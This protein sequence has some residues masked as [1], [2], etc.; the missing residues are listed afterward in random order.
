MRKAKIYAQHQVQDYTLR[1]TEYEGMG[2]LSFTVET[3]ERCITSEKIEEVGNRNGT[4]QHTNH[5]SRYLANHLKTSSHYRVLQAD[6]HNSLPNTVG[7]WF[8]RPS[9]SWQISSALFG[10]FL[11]I[12]KRKRWNSCEKVQK[13]KSLFDCCT[14]SKL[15]QVCSSSES[16]LC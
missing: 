4:D 16:I 1:G 2:F 12:E 3:Y 8:P 5:P 9:V 6:H 15:I 14:F 11:L 10:T 7:P 13:V